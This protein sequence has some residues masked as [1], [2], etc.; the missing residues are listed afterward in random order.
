MS[1]IAVV[2]DSTANIPEELLKQHN[3]YVAPLHITWDK[4]VYRDGIDIKPD[5]FYQRL[6]KSATL[7]TTS[8]AIQSEFIQIFDNLLGKVDGVVVIVVSQN[9]SA[10]YN[11]AVLVKEIYPQLPVEIIDSKSATMAMGFAVIAT[12][13]AASAGG[14]M[15]AVTNAAKDLLSKT[16]L[17]FM[18]DTLEYLKR[19]GRINWPAA[20]FANLL[21]VKPI[22]TL[23]EGKVEPV[24]RPF[25]KPVAIKKLLRLME[26]R[27]TDTPLHVAVA[28]ADDFDG[29]NNLEREIN[30]RF[31]CEEIIITA[32]TPVMGAHT[33]PN[34]LGV[35]FYNE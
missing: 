5:D 2:T 21:K 35:A 19:G 32:F 22:L 6:R 31:K 13:K 15:D 23:R 14:N 25:T 18:L 3:I 27:V 11:S 24:D 17:F 28:H 1:Q 29:A 26:E 9:L 16:H 33:G 8:G 10:A 12:A 4:V 30:L 34:L 20:T 7:P